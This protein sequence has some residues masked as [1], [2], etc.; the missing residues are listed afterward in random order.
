MPYAEGRTFYDADS[1]IMEQAD[2]LKDFADPGYPEQT[3][4]RFYSQNFARL[5][6]L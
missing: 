3:L 2:F 5:F 1:H 6:G 4:E